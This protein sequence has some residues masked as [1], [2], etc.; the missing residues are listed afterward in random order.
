MYA[1]ASTNESTS[2][3][4]DE[5]Q[6]YILEIAPGSVQYTKKK[7]ILTQYNSARII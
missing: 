2:Y 4:N 5:W 1:I 3:I 7:K 6:F